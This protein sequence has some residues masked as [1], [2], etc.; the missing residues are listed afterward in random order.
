MLEPFDVLLRQ[1]AV[2]VVH[3][4]CVGSGEP[5]RMVPIHLGRDAGTGLQPQQRTLALLQIAQHHPSKS[6][7]RIDLPQVK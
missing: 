6:V 1:P 5:G 7:V 3:G 2:D 4:E